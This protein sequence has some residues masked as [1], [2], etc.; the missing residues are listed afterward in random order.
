[1]P[2]RPMLRTST[3][4]T[5]ARMHA[6]LFAAVAA[7][8]ACDAPDPEDEVVA[9]DTLAALGGSS[10]QLRLYD[11][12]LGLVDLKGISLALAPQQVIA[13]VQAGLDDDLGDPACL[14]LVTDDTT[15]LALTFDRCRYRNVFVDGD[16]RIDLTTEEGACDG[17]PCVTATAYT[18]RL[19]DLTIGHTEVRTATSTLRIPTLRGEPRTYTA[20]AELTDDSQRE[21]HLRHEVAWTRAAG[22][23]SAELGAELTVDDTRI[24]VGAH[25]IE[26]CAADCP[27]AGEV[28]LAWASGKSLSWSY[29]GE[30]DIVVHGPRGR[31]FTVTQTCGTTP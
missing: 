6:R 30:P 15:Y 13:Q 19:T 2:L 21:L 25:D 20:E 10:A 22:C 16:L 23:I 29:T 24:S 1:M 12:L 4:A 14:T 18:T 5:L 7:L 27:R 8:S 11:G 3:R 31:T 28:H 17:Q 9:R 26:V